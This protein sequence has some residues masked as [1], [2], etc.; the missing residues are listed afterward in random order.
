[1]T[2]GRV[3]VASSPILNPLSFW[4]VDDEGPGG[5]PGSTIFG[6]VE[7]LFPFEEGCAELE[8]PS[9]SVVL[10]EG[11]FDLAHVQVYGSSADVPCIGRDRSSPDARTQEVPLRGSLVT[12]TRRPGRCHDPGGRRSGKHAR[13]PGELGSHQ[14]IKALYRTRRSETSPHALRHAPRPARVSSGC[15]PVK[16]S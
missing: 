7:F 14:G 15:A 1:L 5:A 4:L 6:P 16:C 11:D 8:F 3:H 13:T 2:R 9:G 12:T 10:H